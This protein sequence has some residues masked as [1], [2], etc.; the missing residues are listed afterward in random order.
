M[1]TFNRFNCF[2]PDLAQKKHNLNTDSFVVALTD[3][4]PVATH[5][6]LANITQIAYTNLSAR[7][8][9]KAYSEVGGQ[10]QL[11]L[12]DLVLTASGNVAQWQWVV[13]YNETA[14]NGELIGW[15]EYPSKVNMTSG[16][17]MTLDFA[18]TSITV[19]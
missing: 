4:Q 6:T 11:A 10:V 14:T 1:A 18:A 7:A 19:G 16:Q 12:T 13:I 9:T 15:I 3:T 17:T 2:I 5:T 8:L